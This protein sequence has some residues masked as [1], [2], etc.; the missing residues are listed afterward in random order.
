[1]TPFLRAEPLLPPPIV[2]NNQSKLVGPGPGY[3][4]ILRFCSDFP[5]LE[6]RGTMRKRM[7]DKSQTPPLTLS[8]CFLLPGTR[9]SS[10]QERYRQRDLCTERLRSL[11]KATQQA[12]EACL[13]P[14]LVCLGHIQQAAHT[15]HNSTD[16]QG[17]PVSQA[18]KLPVW[19]GWFP[20][21]C[22]A[23]GKEG[24]L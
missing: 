1:M 23:W 5:P 19:F 10:Q 18:K 11:P 2:A 17:A 21:W 4:E 15:F 24:S 20:G 7:E 22:P 14:G 12:R 13:I 3:G 16:F 9:S 8:H 6:D